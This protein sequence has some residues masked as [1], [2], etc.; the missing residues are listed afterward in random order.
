MFSHHKK[1]SL[2]LCPIFDGPV[3]SPRGQQVNLFQSESE[4][5]CRASG[6]SWWW[7]VVVAVL[8]C[9][10]WSPGW[11]P[12]FLWRSEPALLVVCVNRGLRLSLLHCEDR[13]IIKN[14][15][16]TCGTVPAHSAKNIVSFLTPD[17]V[18]D[19][20]WMG[21]SW[22]RF[23]W[24]ITLQ[25]WCWKYAGFHL[26]V[27]GKQGA[28]LTRGGCFYVQV[29]HMELRDKSIIPSGWLTISQSDEA[30]SVCC[31][32]CLPACVLPH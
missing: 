8:P 31:S 24:N 7:K 15:F 14:R 26:K 13:Q 4:C 12:W 9:A 23:S 27:E 3:A 5:S 1:L 10:P 11:F 17:E 6:C 30:A 28:H 16:H 25:N 19:A 21:N 29:C 20:P 32:S 18:H 2:S 22:M